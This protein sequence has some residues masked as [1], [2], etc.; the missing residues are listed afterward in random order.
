MT[1]LENLCYNSKPFL[2]HAPG[3]SIPPIFGDLIE[4]LDEKKELW[5]DD[6]DLFIFTVNVPPH[7]RDGKPCGVFEGELKKRGVSCA[8]YSSEKN[9]GIFTLRDKMEGFL[10]LLYSTKAEYSLFADSCD[11]LALASPKEILQKFKSLGK[12]ILFC[13]DMGW[14]LPPDPRYVEYL[15]NR[16]DRNE[17][18]SINAGVF[19][20]RT[21]SLIQFLECAINK[22]GVG[23]DCD[24]TLIQM[25]W[26]EWDHLVHVD[27]RCQLIQNLH[28]YPAALRV[29]RSSWDQAKTLVALINRLPK[30]DKIFGVEIGVYDG[31]TS[32]Y[33]LQEIPNLYLWLVDPWRKEANGKDWYFS[34]CSQEE[35]DRH[36]AKAL[37]YTEFAWDRR[38]IVSEPSILAAAYCSDSSIDFF[39][40]DGDHSYPKVRQSI[41]SWWPKVMRGGFGAGHDYSYQPDST[42]PFGVKK[43]VHEFAEAKNLTVE[44]S[45]IGDVWSVRKD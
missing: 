10:E 12:E 32:A 26:I 14:G 35:L 17:F 41:L 27:S 22:Y 3:L 2:A 11:V 4:V 45:S 33:L 7:G 18:S 40:E 37:R 15:L 43:A 5:E 39:F 8:V 16:P 38:I 42:N 28:Q 6:P 36:K 29:G 21:T 1:I 44:V 30:K 31:R 24:Q 34:D 25:T 19:I 9:L 20:G 23:C 13:P